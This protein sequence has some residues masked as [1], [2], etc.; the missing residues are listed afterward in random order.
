MSVDSLNFQEQFRTALW[1]LVHISMRGFCRYAREQ[2]LSMPQ[3]LILH[4]ISA[5]T[6][7]GCNVSS[8][9]EKM[10]VTNAAISQTLDHLVQQ[11]LVS[12]TEDPQDRRNKRILLTPKGEHVL[13]ESMQSR[14]SWIASLSTRLTQ[15]Q[16]E[17]VL[18][19]IQLL[20]ENIE[21]LE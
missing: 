5:N 13:R 1:Q 15:E 11:G 20:A 14:Q 8:I 6:Q 2:G 10:G 16:K 7:R 9:S 19:S 4:R 21:P 3:L 17:L 12:R 18:R